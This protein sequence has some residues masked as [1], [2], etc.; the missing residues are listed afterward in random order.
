M[1]TATKLADQLL[2]RNPNHGD[3]E[4]MK[5][6]IINSLGNSEE[7]EKQSSYLLGEE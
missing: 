4:A 5:A 6:L 7:G 1:S 2:K 3:T